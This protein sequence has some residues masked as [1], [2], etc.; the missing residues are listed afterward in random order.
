MSTTPTAPTPSATSTDT[1]PGTVKVYT[2]DLTHSE[3]AF[4]VRHLVTKVRGRFNDYAATIRMDTAN[5]EASSVEFRVKAASIDTANAD[6]DTH[7][8]S[9]DF[10]DVEKFPEIIF[11]STAI[12]PSTK[13]G[14]D[15][16]EVY[17]VTGNLEMH[18]VTKEITLPVTYLGTARDPWGNDKAGFETTTKINRKDFDMVWNVALDAGGFILSEDIKIHINLETQLQK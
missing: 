13:R 4:T 15:D 1:I 12:R 7:L 9:A 8:R 17:D 18:G 14:D 10:F 2:L 5:P 6:R 16:E 3:V 11:R